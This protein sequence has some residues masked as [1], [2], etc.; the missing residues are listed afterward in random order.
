M[1]SIQYEALQYDLM[2]QLGVPFERHRTSNCISRGMAH[3]DIML[4][5]DERVILLLADTFQAWNLGACIMSMAIKQ[6][7]RFGYTMTGNRRAQNDWEHHVHEVGL[8]HS[9]SLSTIEIRIYHS[10][11]LQYFVGR[12][13]SMSGWHHN[14]SI[15][16][17]IV[18]STLQMTLTGMALLTSSHIF[19]SI[20]TFRFSCVQLQVTVC[21]VHH[22]RSINHSKH[23]CISLIHI[24]GT[25]IK[26]AID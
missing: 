19:T 2:M 13:D 12:L 5:D 10:F 6:M 3:F 11:A 16:L 24:Y 4:Q 20:V 1:I 18:S 21:D 15:F 8:L 17:F 9:C 25:W 7:R 22:F 14:C 23:R 26:E